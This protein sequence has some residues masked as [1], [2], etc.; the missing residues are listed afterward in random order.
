MSLFC[1]LQLMSA[2]LSVIYP[3]YSFIKCQTRIYISPAKYFLQSLLLEKRLIFRSAIT[4]QTWSPLQTDRQTDRQALL[5]QL[6]TTFARDTITIRDRQLFLAPDTL[7]QTDHIIGG[8]NC[9]SYQFKKVIKPTP[10]HKWAII[11]N[12][13]WNFLR[14][15]FFPRSFLLS[16][17]C[18]AKYLIW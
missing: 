18:L 3:F 2:K 8:H 9:A 10:N 7:F 12:F 16:V 13:I 14:V 6:Q 4:K 15:V 1:T 17:F 11:P 5:F